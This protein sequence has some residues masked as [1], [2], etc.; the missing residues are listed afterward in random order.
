MARINKT[1]TVTA[2]G[3][4]NIVSGLDALAAVN[5]GPQPRVMARSLFIQMIHGGTGRGLVMDGVYGVQSTD[6]TPRI[7]SAAATGDVTAEL[8]PATATA[9][10]GSYSDS[11]VLPNGAGGIQVDKTWIDGTVPGDL[12]KVSYDTIE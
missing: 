12:I 5:I 4:V 3:A 2:N 8:Q 7:P 9:P 10:G 11:Y 1:I 6:Q